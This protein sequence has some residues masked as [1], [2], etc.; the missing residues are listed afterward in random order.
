MNVTLPDGDVDGVAHAGLTGPADV[1]FGVGFDATHMGDRPFTVIVEGDGTVSARQLDNHAPGVRLNVSVDVLSHSV[2]GGLRSVEGAFLTFTSDDMRLCVCGKEG[3]IING[4]YQTPNC[5]APPLTSLGANPSCSV[6]TY[7]GGL[8]CCLNGDVLL[9]AEQSVESKEDEFFV[10]AR[11]YFEEYTTQQFASPMTWLT[12]AVHYEYD[13]PQCAAG[14]PPSQCVHSLTSYY[15]G[16]QLFDLCPS[17]TGGSAAA[18]GD[19]CYVPPGGGFDVL[20]LQGHLH[21]PAAISLDLYDADSGLLLCGVR[22]RYG[23]GDAH[24]DERG[25]LAAVPPC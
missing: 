5:A 9:D 17:V 6:E 20:T 4:Q 21:G 12:E 8:Q 13:I 3:G 16:Q 23:T 7:V 19:A 22:A 1:W 11:F 25:Y 18:P 15:T 24:Y 10:R 2:T 14:T